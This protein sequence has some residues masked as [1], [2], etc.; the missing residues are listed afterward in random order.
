[1]VADVLIDETVDL[2]FDQLMGVAQCVVSTHIELTI[3]IL[4]EEYLS[5]FFVIQ[6]AE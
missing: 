5:F 6:V 2:W 1:M 4:T 3:M